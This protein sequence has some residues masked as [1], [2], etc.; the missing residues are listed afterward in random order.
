LL[1]AGGAALFLVQALGTEQSLREQPHE[2]EEIV[3]LLNQAGTNRTLALALGASA[4]V[5]LAVG[6]VGFVF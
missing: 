4:G 1:L 3:T 2:R 6:V 5:A